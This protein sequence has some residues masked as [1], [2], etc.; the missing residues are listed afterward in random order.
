VSSREEAFKALYRTEFAALAGYCWQLQ[1]DREA[2]AET[3]QEAFARL[4]GKWTGVQQPR[5]YVYRI[6]TNIIRDSWTSQKRNRE[7]FDAL[8]RAAEDQYEP[9]QAAAV[10]VRTAVSALPQRLRPVVLLHYYADL[11]VEDVASATRRPVGSVKRQLSEART[12]LATQLQE[13]P[14]A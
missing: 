2:A 11:T 5:A 12:L 3:A 6:A 13:S 1:G 8:T 10:A 7:T 14:S 9:D 4:F